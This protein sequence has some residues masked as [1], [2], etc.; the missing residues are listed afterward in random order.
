[1]L[2]HQ[3][4]LLGDVLTVSTERIEPGEHASRA[5][6]YIGL[7]HIEGH[8]G[9]LLH[10]DHTFGRDIQSTKN[11]FHP[12]QILYGKLRPYLNKVHLSQ[13]D[14]ICSTDIYVLNPRQDRITPAYAAYFLGSSRVLSRVSGLMH[15][16]NLPRISSQAL[17]GL[18]I[19]LPS[20]SEQQ[21]IVATLD[22]AAN[23]RTLRAQADRRTADLI[24]ALFRKMFGDPSTNQMRW[25]SALLADLVQEFRYGSSKKSA[26]SGKPTLRI[27]NVVGNRI[28]LAHL[29]LVPVDDREYERLRLLDGDILFVRTNGNPDYVGRSAVFYSDQVT[30]SGFASDQ[31]IYASYLI[32][33]RLKPHCVD[34][35]FLQHYL[36]AEAGRQDIRARARTAAG[37]Y[38]INTEGLGELPIPCPPLSLQQ[39]FAARVSEIRALEAK[40]AESRRRIDDLFQSLLHRAFA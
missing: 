23:L 7:E 18:S 31:F 39:E 30:E 13:E 9:R 10:H 33:A 28:D 29:K 5:F 14:G 1:M 12:D 40:Q 24:P 27:P 3:D 19:P 6:N 21:R 32:R 2:S 4:A 8:R 16:A 20:L 37:Q 11:V 15:G 22:A 36:N 25:G 35:Y 34:P 17:L 38:N 26:P